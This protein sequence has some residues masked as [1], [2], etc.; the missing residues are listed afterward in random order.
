ME[1][2]ENTQIMADLG[3]GTTE[4]IH[5]SFPGISTGVPQ[6]TSAGRK[7]LSSLDA[8]DDLGDLSLTDDE[9]PV[10]PTGGKLTGKHSILSPVSVIG[11]GVWS[12]SHGAAPM[13]RIKKA[14][15]LKSTDSLLEVMM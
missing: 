3:A 1:D 8:P 15:P 7:W 6:A 5:G 10:S 2:T 13:M 14:S 12:P 11:V 9:E 4:G